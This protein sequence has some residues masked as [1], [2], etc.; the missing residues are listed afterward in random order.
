MIWFPKKWAKTIHDLLSSFPPSFPPSLFPS[1]PSPRPSSSPPPSTPATATSRSKQGP[2]DERVES[3]WKCCGRC[4]RN[5]RRRTTIS[6]WRQVCFYFTFPSLPPSLSLP[7]VQETWGE[8]GGGLCSV[9]LLLKGS[10]ANGWSK[11][12]A[13]SPVPLTLPPSLPPSPPPS[14]PPITTHT[15]RKRPGV[16]TAGGCVPSSSF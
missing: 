6:V 11:T 9:L 3:G 4:T 16:R 7:S 1:L 15:Q 13:E 2:A 8:N 12:E 10:L 5:G 14:L